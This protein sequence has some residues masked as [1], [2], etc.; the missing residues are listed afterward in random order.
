VYP[1]D[2]NPQGSTASERILG[3]RPGPDD[4]MIAT[5]RIVNARMAAGRS[6]A[7]YRA[8]ERMAQ[9]PLAALQR[10]CEALEAACYHLFRLVDDADDMARS[11]YALAESA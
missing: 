1:A 11:A 2:P 8:S 4:S 3:P 7:A 5:A 6:L 10:R 9:D